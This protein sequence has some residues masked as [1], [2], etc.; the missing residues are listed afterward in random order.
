MLPVNEGTGL[1]VRVHRGTHEVGGSCVELRSGDA[2][3]VLDV[4][5]PLSA[6]PDDDVPLPDVAGLADGSDPNLAG[7]VISHAHL[8][9]YGLL[10]KVS[11]NVPV[12]AG[13]AAAA[14][15]EAA[16][17]FYPSGP[18]LRPTTPLSDRVPIRV[19][20][21][22]ITPYLVDHSAFDAYSVL[23]DAGGRRLLYTGDLRAHGRKRAL[24]DEFVAH[25]PAD[26]D[27]LLMEGTQ[28]GATPELQDGHH[29]WSEED[30]EDALVT[31]MK[32]TTGLVVVAA[33]PQNVDRLVTAFKAARR[34]GRV[35]LLDLYGV[36]VAMA[37]GRPT[38]PQPGFDGLGV[39]VPQRQRV[40]VKE[41]GQFGR[42]VSVRTIRVFPEQLA[43][44]PERH[45]LYGS[46]S[47]IRELVGAGALTAAGTVVWSMWSGYLR[48]P[49]GRRLQAMLDEHCI[50]L[51]EHHASGHATVADLQRLVQA[52]N[53]AVVVPIHTDG[54]DRFADLFQN[55]QIHVDDEWWSV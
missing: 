48:D 53:P 29:G 46:S 5:R 41:S 13:E 6:S 15:V 54:L 25:P 10:D 23:V 44:H 11:P 37:T 30:V 14:I 1:H 40:L 45:A 21:F 47:T 55:V 27:V 34:S 16:R 2:R 22:T 18:E 17:F 50:R 26:V 3:L 42:T 24:F 32:D 19:G 9:H 33:S 35:L 36:A 28:V 51:V 8:D 20:A 38:I 7:V 43:A 12:F 39:F 49:S 31:T 52:V 4:G